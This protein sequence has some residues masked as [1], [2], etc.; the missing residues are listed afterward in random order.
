M[1]EHLDQLAFAFFKIFAQYE[2]A[3]K[4]QGFFK[5]RGGAIL[6]DWDR[7]ANERVGADFLAKLGASQPAAE[8]ILNELPKKQVVDEKNQFV[9]AP[10]SNQD[11]SVQAL[12]GHLSRMRN[13]LFHGAKFNG[14]WFDP[15]RS[16]ALLSNGTQVLQ[17]LRAVAGV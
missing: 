10:V 8:F 11:R 4:E 13:N 17:S 9:W 6:V 3:L 2:S 7:F 16:E 15:D 12:F 14:T 1:S 5:V